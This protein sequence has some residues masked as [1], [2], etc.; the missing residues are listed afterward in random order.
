MLRLRLSRLLIELVLDRGCR[1]AGADDADVDEKNWFETVATTT[2]LA[3]DGDGET[4]IF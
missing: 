2:D 4:A 1:D 3:P